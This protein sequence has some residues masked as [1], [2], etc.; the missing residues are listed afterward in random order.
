MR[1]LLE[2]EQVLGAPYGLLH[3]REPPLD[4]VVQGQPLS[5]AS[6]VRM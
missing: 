2:L 4:G 6:A 5:D 3:E 1:L